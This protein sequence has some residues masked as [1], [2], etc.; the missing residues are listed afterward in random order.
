MRQLHLLFVLLVGIC[1]VPAAAYDCCAG[2]MCNENWDSF[3]SATGN[4][5][6][7][8]NGGKMQEQTDVGSCSCPSLQ[9]CD[10]GPKA[11]DHA[12]P[13]NKE[14]RTAP[15]DPERPFE[16]VMVGCTIVLVTMMTIIFCASMWKVGSGYE[17]I[18]EALEK[19]PLQQGAARS[20]PYSAGGG[21]VGPPAA[22]Q[23]LSLAEE[24]KRRQ[25]QQHLNNPHHL[26]ATY[27]SG[28]QNR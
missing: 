2:R 22:H 25:Q 3:D 20:L 24:A 28:Y 18:N 14:G 8:P 10:M 19:L 4:C 26:P 6:M 21:Y 17:K 16:Y 15:A 27:Y 11:E 1:T 5:C 7:L 23:M 12:P 9:Q 13:I